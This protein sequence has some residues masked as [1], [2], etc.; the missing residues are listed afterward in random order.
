MTRLSIEKLRAL[1]GTIY[2]M[3]RTSEPSTEMIH[4]VFLGREKQ[5]EQ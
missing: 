5:I 4:A 1:E 3:G 2:L